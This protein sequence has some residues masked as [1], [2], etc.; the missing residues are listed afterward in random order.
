MLIISRT[1]LRLTLG[2]GGTD[3]PSYYSKFE[4]FVVTSSLNKH[5]YVVMKDRF[6]EE[7][8]VSYSSTEIASNINDAETLHDAWKRGR[9]FPKSEARLSVRVNALC[10]RPSEI[11]IR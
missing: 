4:G 7:V 2:G 6:E 5:I 8:R 9:A 10:K 11:R 1:P 3:L